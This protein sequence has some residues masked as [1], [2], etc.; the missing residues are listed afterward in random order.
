[1][2]LCVALVQLP[3]ARLADT[4]EPVH[5]SGLFTQGEDEE[6]GHYTRHAEALRLRR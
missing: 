2:S 5:T 4:G 6:D 3:R 1:M